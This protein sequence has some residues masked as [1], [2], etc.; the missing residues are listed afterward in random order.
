MNKNII[1][2]AVGILVVGAGAYFLMNRQSPAVASDGHTDHTHDEATTTSGTHTM[3]DG[4]TMGM[5]MST[6]A[7]LAGTRVIVKNTSYKTGKQ[8]LSFV[9]YGKDG[10]EYGD[11]DLKVAHEKK[12]HFIVVSN[13]FSNYQHLHP[14]FKDKLWQVEI[15]LKNN[16]G[17]QAYVDVDSV[18]VGAEILRFPILVGTMT[19]LPKVSQNES[20]LKIDNTS[21]AI[22]TGGN[23]LAG[24]DNSI[25]FKVSKN[26]NTVVPENYLGAKGHVVALG[27]NSDTF[28]HGHPNDH[29]DSDVHFVFNFANAGTYTLFA[30]FKVDGVVRT[31]PFTVKVGTG[32]TSPNAVDES[33]P[34]TDA[35]P[36]N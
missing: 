25:V 22:E 31:Y 33:M 8:T 2:G 6:G 13:D 21:V 18:E 11:A 36:H 32:S 1:F 28:I 29:E 19:N 7:K 27:D 14:E 23:L 17:Y 5:N 4:S 15:N 30:Q 34:H 26:G 16:T 24:K 10:H 35:V 3:P 12:M 9:L 20:T